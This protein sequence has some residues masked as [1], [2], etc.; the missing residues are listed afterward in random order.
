MYKESINQRLE[1][2]IRILIYRKQ[3]CEITLKTVQPGTGR[4]QKPREELARN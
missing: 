2:G 4:H 1:K 3:S